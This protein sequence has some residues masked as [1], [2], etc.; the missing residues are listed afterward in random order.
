MSLRTLAPLAEPAI[1]LKT[2][3]DVQM[4]SAVR[5]VSPAAVHNGP[6]V[7]DLLA[8][9]VAATG[10]VAVLRETAAGAA[11]VDGAPSRSLAVVLRQ[12]SPAGAIPLAALTTTGGYGGDPVAFIGALAGALLAPLLA[13]L[14][15]G[16]ALEAH[17]QN[18]LAVVR[19]GR[20]A[21][22]AYRDMGGVR[23]SPARLRAH[24]VEPP[25]LHGD[26]PTDD[27]AV[28]RTKV[29]ASAGVALAERVA[30]LSRAHGVPPA[31]LWARVAAV[32]RSV[33]DADPADLAGLFAPTLPVKA[34][35]AMRL[36]AD[37]LQDLW[38]EL[39]NPLAAWA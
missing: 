33:P 24:G 12:T 29:Y 30:V 23:I 19:D 8:H 11:L 16:A 3:V 13:L 21:A 31:A 22:I 36:A 7:S 4:T 25:P 28:L 26:I 14:R 17:G 37:P 15:R 10:G 9:L 38:A 27:P 1:H 32:A 35:T 20:I 34:T 2:A 5:T 18:T 6:A 39:P